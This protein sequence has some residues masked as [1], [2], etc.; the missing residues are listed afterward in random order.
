M[1]AVRTPASPDNSFEDF[2]RDAVYRAI[3]TRRDVRSHFPAQTPSTTP[4]WRGF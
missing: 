3:F 2:E 4:C 1:H